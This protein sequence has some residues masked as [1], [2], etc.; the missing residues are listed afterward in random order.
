M[1]I[2]WGWC[3]AVTCKMDRKHVLDE[4][5]SEWGSKKVRGVVISGNSIPGRGEASTKA[6]WQEHPWRA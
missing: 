6:P 5:I 1:V 4:V 3:F 2:R